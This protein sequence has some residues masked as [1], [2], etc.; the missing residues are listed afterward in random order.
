MIRTVSAPQII[1]IGVFLFLAAVVVAVAPL[2][3]LLRSLGVLLFSY[4]A[5]A[6]GGMP[7]AYLTALLAPPLAL[8]AG[9]P[10]WLVM[11][12]MMLSGNLLAML[13]LEYGW[14]RP[15]LVVSPL[16]MSVPL[17]F[18]R[19]ASRRDLFTVSLPWDS[20]AGLWI[21]LHMLVAVAGILVAIVLDRRRAQQS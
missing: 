17:I 7:F 19:I 10:D 6:M 12:P 18:V 9:D 21:T 2:P 16:L 11:L 3:L 20:V 14:R 15:A 4:L 5:F 1:V 8:I 13:G